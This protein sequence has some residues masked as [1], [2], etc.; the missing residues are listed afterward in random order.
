VQKYRF[1]S[2]KSM[3]LNIGYINYKIGIG[4]EAGGKKG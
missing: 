1:N 4:A 2:C 3:N